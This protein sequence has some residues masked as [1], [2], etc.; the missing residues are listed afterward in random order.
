MLSF[1]SDAPTLAAQ[2][3]R[4][5]IDEQTP[6]AGGH[7]FGDTG[8]YERSSGDCTSRSI[9]TTPPTPA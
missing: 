6:F 7:P 4:V 1:V 3:V 8:P 5:E 9:R 2:V